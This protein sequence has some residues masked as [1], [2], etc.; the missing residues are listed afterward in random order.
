MPYLPG[1]VLVE[2][3]L[4]CL[5]TVEELEHLDEF[6]EFFSAPPICNRHKDLFLDNVSLIDALLQRLYEESDSDRVGLL[7]RALWVMTVPD[8][9]VTYFVKDDHLLKLVAVVTQFMSNAT[10][11]GPQLDA[12]R[13]AGL[14]PLVVTLFGLHLES[15]KVC[16]ML[17]KAVGNLGSNQ[18]EY[19]DAFYGA[20]LL[21]R[22]CEVMERHRYVADTMQQAL[23][24]LGSFCQIPAAVDAILDGGVMETLFRSLRDRL[25][26]V[27]ATT[28]ALNSLVHILNEH[29]RAQTLFRARGGF[30]LVGGLV[31]GALGREKDLT[32]IGFS[33]FECAIDED[34]PHPHRTSPCHAM[35]PAPCPPPVR[36]GCDAGLRVPHRA[37]APPARSGRR[38]DPKAAAGE[39]ASQ[40]GGQQSARDSRRACAC[41]HLIVSHPPLRGAAVNTQ[42]FLDAGL[43]GVMARAWALYAADDPELLMS[44]ICICNAIVLHAGAPVVAQLQDGGMGT[45]ML[46]LV[47]RRVD[48]EPVATNGLRFFIVALQQSKEFQAIFPR[49]RF[50]ELV[51]ACLDAHPD[52]A[53]TCHN[54]CIA[55]RQLCDTRPNRASLLGHPTLLTRFAGLYRDHHADP[56]LCEE[57]ART[58][59][60]LCRSGRIGRALCRHQMAGA[61]LEHAL[62]ADDGGLV[63]WYARALEA[64]LPS[65]PEA[66]DA[67]K[68]LAL[69]KQLLGFLARALDDFA[70]SGP[71]MGCVCRCL[72]RL[73]APAHPAGALLERLEADC[74]Q[75]TNRLVAACL[76][77]DR[78][79]ANPFMLHWCALVAFRWP[80]SC[81]LDPL[82]ATQR[83][84][85][86]LL[87]TAGPPCFEAALQLLA[88]LIGRASRGAVLPG[89]RA[90][91]RQGP[92]G[93]LLGT[94]CTRH[95]PGR[96]RGDRALWAELLAALRSL[97][98][99][100]VQQ[101]PAAHVAQLLE[102]PEGPE[103][104]PSAAI[105]TPPPRPSPPGSS[106]SQHTTAPTPRHG[107]APTPPPSGQ[108][109][110][111][112]PA[113]LTS[114]RGICDVVWRQ[115]QMGNSPSFQEI[116][117]IDVGLAQQIIPS[118]DE[119]QTLFRIYDKSGDG[120]LQRDEAMVFCR[121]TVELSIH[122]VKDR[123]PAEM[124]KGLIQDMQDNKELYATR[125]FNT[126]DVNKDGNLQFAE[127]SAYVRSM[128]NQL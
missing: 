60:A 40:Q 97:D 67:E 8:G 85:V 16:E 98:Q 45:G 46:D 31:A 56:E 72:Y 51:G 90:L 19:A 35:L 78:L 36:L 115:R 26:G 127:F 2:D 7:F 17:C 50:G 65:W 15:P 21:G 48:F 42:C 86:T 100:L 96:S 38:S 71:M 83:T 122:K 68:T 87:D 12:M 28:S 4:R 27:E 10:V 18:I 30:E 20:G 74:M 41:G 116:K 109:P 120:I 80:D 92:F 88:T 49:G 79:L 118:D 121:E 23:G 107:G 43:V 29:P 91:L 25:P 32:S 89:L 95:P 54:A 63:W 5:G 6:I 61:L 102:V 82:V 81:V 1:S 47:A 66:E 33:V 57:V 58:T 114:F 55:I 69:A 70:G 53:L 76:E 93:Q 39:S 99:G 101:I 113:D 128:G 9:N 110:R 106:P 126:A 77:D 37:G 73:A 75:V 24:C 13:E 111:I 84:L 94:F 123:L 11:G 22:V 52:C 117:R 108:P 104:P 125:A 112:R 14:V 62:E 34:G 124:S 3:L 44:A 119:L 103:P 105:P 64:L 59:V